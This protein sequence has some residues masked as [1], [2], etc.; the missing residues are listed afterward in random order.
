[1]FEA[2]PEP[3]LDDI[4]EDESLGNSVQQSDSS[5]YSADS[6]ITIGEDYEAIQMPIH[7]GLLPDEQLDDDE[8]DRIDE[9]Q[10]ADREV[11]GDAPAPPDII[12][13]DD[14]LGDLWDITLNPD[15]LP[16]PGQRIVF[17]DKVTRLKLEAQVTLMF[18]SVQKKHPG[19]RNI[20]VD[21]S[22]H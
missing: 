13:H 2:V 5:T 17:Y 15:I 9:D 8:E 20:L 4:D 6:D 12:A 3:D 16:I 14:E 18:K 11:A 21:D 22:P 7:L 19:W 1:M 10:A